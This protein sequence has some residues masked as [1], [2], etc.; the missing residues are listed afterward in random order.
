MC[1]FYYSF[2]FRKYDT[3]FDRLWQMK[4]SVR[5]SL[6]DWLLAS[7]VSHESA[8]NCANACSEMVENCIKYASN[9]S[10]AG[11]SICVKDT[12]ILV[13]TS[14]HAEAMHRQEL[15][16]SI[17]ALNEALDLS[18]LFVQKLMNPEE[19]VSQLGLIKI[20]METKGRLELLPG[21]EPDIAHVRLSMEADRERGHST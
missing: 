19:G 6:Q 9:D 8:E 14:N 12:S 18:Q 17:V 4:S 10:Q 21:Q 7:A 11:V 15:Q 2:Q 16:E 1:E 13:E 3:L 20:M 5:E